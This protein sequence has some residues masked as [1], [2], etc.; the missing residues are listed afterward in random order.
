MF[1]QID[2]S[3]DKSEDAKKKR[4]NK[5]RRHI[6]HSELP[7]EMVQRRNKRERERIHAVNDAFEKLKEHLPNTS[8]NDKSSKVQIL[9][10]AILYIKNLT[11]LLQHGC[12]PLP[13][14]CNQRLIE[15]HPEAGSRMW[16]NEC[17]QGSGFV[18]QVSEQ[19]TGLN[20]LDTYFPVLPYQNLRTDL[21]DISKEVSLVCE[22]NYHANNRKF[23]QVRYHVDNGG[24]NSLQDITNTCH[25][26]GNHRN[27]KNVD[28]IPSI[29]NARY[30]A[31]PSDIKIASKEVKTDF[32]EDLIPPLS[33][34]VRNMFKFV[35]FF[36]G[37]LK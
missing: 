13:F 32:L 9:N 14:D 36:T 35:E 28:K 22:R 29:G 2:Y 31:A 6:P 30:M 16:D 37:H 5:R 19:T 17:Y 26:I 12:N 8:S 33:I 4:R 7:M 18:Q 23:Q 21:E 11:Y 25:A 1:S 27:I 3:L 20:T 34:Q 24:R 10:D 15:F